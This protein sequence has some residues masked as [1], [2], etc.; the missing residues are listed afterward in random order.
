MILENLAA[1]L[2]TNNIGCVGKDLFVYKMPET[3][4]EGTLLADHAEMMV[5][6]YIP[7]YRNGV[8]RVVVRA[9]DYTS[10]MNRARSIMNLLTKQG[11]V[12]DNVSIRTVYPR[13]EP[14]VFHYSEG[15]TIEMLLLFNVIYEITNYELQ[16]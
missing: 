16:L 8:V 3:A 4:V 12:L 2:D 15:D 9:T 7:D 5:D 11:L 1:Y 6:P 10:G 14:I 13:H